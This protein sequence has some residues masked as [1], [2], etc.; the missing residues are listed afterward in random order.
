MWIP[1]TSNLQKSNVKDHPGSGMHKYFFGRHFKTM[2][3]GADQQA[4]LL[5]PPGIKTMIDGIANMRIEE[6]YMVS[7]EEIPINK[8][9]VLVGNER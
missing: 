9:G 7:K 3:M 8:F 1:G 2:G 5:S 4:A 6:V